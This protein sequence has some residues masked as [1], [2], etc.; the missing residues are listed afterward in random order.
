MISYPPLPYLTGFLQYP[1]AYILLPYKRH[2]H[3]GINLFC[4]ENHFGDCSCE[5][6]AEIKGENILGNILMILRQEFIDGFFTTS[7]HSSLVFSDNVDYRDDYYFN[8]FSKTAILKGETFAVNRADY[9]N[10]DAED[11]EAK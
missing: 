3:L 5:K 1:G 4:H 2:R 9:Q 10:D 8:A 7:P 11:I 6:C